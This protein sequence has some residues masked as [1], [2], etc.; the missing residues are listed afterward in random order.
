MEEKKQV[1][2]L[3]RRI[4]F[5]EL[6]YAFDWISEEEYTSEMAELIPKYKSLRGM[7]KSICGLDIPAFAKEYKIVEEAKVVEN[8]SERVN[9]N[10]KG[11]GDVI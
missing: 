4:H 11:G 6:V 10:G 2:V 3:I 1:Y 5:L 9:S 8:A 7:L